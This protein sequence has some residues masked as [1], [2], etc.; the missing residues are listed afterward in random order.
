MSPKALPSGYTLVS[1][2]CIDSTNAEAV[3]LARSN[4]P[5]VSGNSVIWALEQ[6]GGRGRRG[7]TWTSPRGNLYCSIIVRPPVP[8]AHAAQ[9]GYV[10]ALAVHDL[11]VSCCRDTA[12]VHTK[13]PNDVLINGKKASG[14]LLESS[15]SAGSMIDWLVIGIGIN[16]AHFPTDTAFEATSLDQESPTPVTLEETLYQ[17]IAAF[18]RWYQVWLDQGFQAIRATWIEKARGIGED[19]I[20]RL[21]KQELSGIFAGIDPDGALVLRQ[22]SGDQLISAGDLFFPAKP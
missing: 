12:L 4:A 18:D 13:W 7:R 3:R 9:T 16:V 20:V 1:L 17:L 22:Q 11:M 19:I 15:M 10:A 8:L 21:E 2:D 14:I 6:S 5:S